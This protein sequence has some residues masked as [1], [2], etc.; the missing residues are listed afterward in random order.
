MIELVEERAALL[1]EYIAEEREI[2]DSISDAPV[3][4]TTSPAGINVE[5][6][7]TQAMSDVARQLSNE[8][9]Q[10]ESIDLQTIQGM[11]EADGATPIATPNQEQ[12]TPHSSPTHLIANRDD[13]APVS[14]AIGRWSLSQRIK[15]G[16]KDGLFGEHSPSFLKVL[17][18]SQY[19][20]ALNNG[21]I[22]T[23][24]SFLKVLIKSD[25]AL[26]NGEMWM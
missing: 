13:E 8:G 1:Q 4:T 3:V 24:Y 23:W 2:I 11:E 21:E 25:K 12:T 18:G 6:G 20:K 5:H 7:I 19:D 10:I 22:W 14:G 26:N 16:R 15:K 9:K 17:I